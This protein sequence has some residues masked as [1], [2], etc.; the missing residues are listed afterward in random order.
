M[1]APEAHWL[2]KLSFGGARWPAPGSLFAWTLAAGVV[3]VGTV[4]KPT[5]ELISGEVLPPYITF[6]P[7]VVMAALGGGPIIGVA[8]AFATLVIA[9]FLFQSVPSHVAAAAIYACTS[10]FLGWMVGNARLAFDSARA[11]RTHQAYAARESVHRIKNLIAVVQAIIRKV[12][13]EVRTTEQFRDILSERMTGLEIAQRVLVEQDW[14]DVP[15]GNLLNSALAPFLPNPGLT[16]RR[17]PEATI[18]AEC[19]RGVSMALYE[20]CTNAM[21]YGALAEGRGPVLLSWK[22]EAGRVVLDWEEK[23]ATDPRHTEGF[24]ATLI[25]AALAGHPEARV[26]YRVDPD[27][28]YASFQWAPREPRSV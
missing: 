28:I 27:G 16:L 17:G 4:L 26:D 21:K 1:K 22:L 7:A 18:P 15:L 9:W 5:L 14:Q 8:S 20:L 3:L 13:R 11:S 2:A 23:T 24:G 6:Y 10:V 25:R 19:V 12:F